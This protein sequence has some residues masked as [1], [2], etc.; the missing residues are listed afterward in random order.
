M[1][2]YEVEW[3]EQ[4]LTQA[5]RA[6]GRLQQARSA[7]L[8]VA[9]TGTSAGG[10]ISVTCDGSGGVTAVALDPRVRRLDLA[11]LG[12]EVT[13]ALRAAQA[14]AERQAREL[15]DA[16]MAETGSLPVPLDETA[17]RDRIEQVVREAL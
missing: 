11:E 17:I 1:S 6:I 16:V 5:R 10:L 12:K 8:S 4:A 13:A 15:A 3:M 14:E 7:I 9:G 2:T